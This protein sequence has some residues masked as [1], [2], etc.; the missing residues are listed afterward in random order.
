MPEAPGSGSFVVEDEEGAAA[1]DFV[2]A[3]S[4]SAAVAAAS[5]AP[6]ASNSRRVNGMAAFV[7]ARKRGKRPGRGVSLFLTGRLPA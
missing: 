6:R 3:G 4:V 1:D 5:P 2:H 7:P